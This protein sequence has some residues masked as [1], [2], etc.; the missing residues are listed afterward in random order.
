[1]D[2]LSVLVATILAVSVASERIVEILKG[3]FPTLWPFSPATGTAEARRTAGI[4]ILAGLAG[5]FVAWASGINLLAMLGLSGNAA[6]GAIYTVLGYVVVGLLA[7]GGSA[8]WNQVLDI[9]QAA[10]VQQEQKTSAMLAANNAQA[11]ANVP[12][13]GQAVPAPAAI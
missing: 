1:M 2:K 12:A 3:L 9:M 8:F 7:S 4:H 11:P 6:G 13:Q 5:A 10:K